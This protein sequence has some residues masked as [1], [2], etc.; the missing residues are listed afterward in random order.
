MRRDRRT[1]MTELIGDFAAM[2]TP[3]KPLV[4]SLLLGRLISQY[5]GSASNIALSACYSVVDRGMEEF[6]GDG[7]PKHDLVCVWGVG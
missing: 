6:K 4:C 5:D 2:A 1:Y 3:L 7:L